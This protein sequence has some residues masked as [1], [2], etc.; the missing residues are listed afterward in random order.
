MPRLF[1]AY[2][3]KRANKALTQCL[4]FSLWLLTSL[5]FSTS[6]S[7]LVE[8]TRPLHFGTLAVPTNTAPEHITLHLNEQHSASSGIV[9][10]NKPRLGL[11]EV[12][13]L[14]ANVS[15]N[16]SFTST[17]L[18]YLGTGGGEGLTL[19]SFEVPHLFTSPTGTLQFQVG[20]TATSSG[21][22]L[23]YSNGDYAANARLTL[24]YWSPNDNQYREHY[25]EFTPTA[26]MQVGVNLTEE[27]PLH[28]GTLF[29]TSDPHNESELEVPPS[30]NNT[31]V[32]NSGNARIVP[33]TA[34]QP[35]VLKVTGAAAN[36]QVSI[37]L[38][39]SE[40][41]LKH[42]SNTQAPSLWIKDFQSSPS[43]T[44]ITDVN[45]ELT[46]RIGATLRTALTPVQAV[47]PEGRYIGSYTVT[48]SY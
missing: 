15:A 29:I 5:F 14:P 11:F 4:I 26:R 7:I 46:I 39:S 43:A 6:A 47:Y 2:K 9:I 36:Y 32:S 10:I 25:Y 45:G 16:L 37:S 44:G 22:S 8:E 3:S 19:S 41:E 12:S 31:R 28:F 34:A 30:G 1:P 38:P 42:S 23:G 27:Q 35:G 17:P 48:V 33:I 21:T 13:G 24:R 20:A 40:V 18:T